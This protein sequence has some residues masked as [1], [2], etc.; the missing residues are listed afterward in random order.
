[1]PLA[2]DEPT[3]RHRH[4]LAAF[5]GASPPNGSLC[6]LIGAMIA[7][8]RTACSHHPDRQRPTHCVCSAALALV[9]APRL[10]RQP[11]VD[12]TL[13]SYGQH[14]H[15]SDE[16]VNRDK[17]SICMALKAA[18]ATSSRNPGYSQLSHSLICQCRTF[19]LRDNIDAMRV[20]TER[21]TT[22][23]DYTL[24]LWALNPYKDGDFSMTACEFLVRGRWPA[25]QLLLYEFTRP[26]EWRARHALVRWRPYEIGQTRF[27]ETEG[28]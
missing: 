25:A 21:R 3:F 9:L 8:R 16:G 20:L 4:R 27:N 11:R 7:P 2:D 13:R 5:P 19:V 1:M 24:S 26:P 6:A 28:Q 15:P 17:R 14:N 18:A 23:V 22:N 12:I 10:G